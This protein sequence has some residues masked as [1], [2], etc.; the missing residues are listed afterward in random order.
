LPLEA[1]RI[2]K[3]GGKVSYAFVARVEGVLAVSRALGDFQFKIKPEA[4]KELKDAHQ[5]EFIGS[6]LQEPSSLQELKLDSLVSSIP[7]IFTYKRTNESSFFLVSDGITGTVEDQEMIDYVRS[8]VNGST[9]EER[10]MNLLKRNM[11]Y[12]TDDQTLVYVKL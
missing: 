3:L 1:E 2:K 7:E 9:G 12:I 10:C 5:D 11:Q 8:E 4:I 6:Y